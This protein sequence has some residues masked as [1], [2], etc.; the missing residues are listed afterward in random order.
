MNPG[1]KQKAKKYKRASEEETGPT[2]QSTSLQAAGNRAQAHKLRV[3]ASS[4]SQQAL[5][6]F[7]QGTSV[8]APGPG[9]RQQGQR[10][11]FCA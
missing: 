2:H 6:F 9:Y 4:L 1:K 11:F 10:Y 3:Q 8:Q 5:K 7:I